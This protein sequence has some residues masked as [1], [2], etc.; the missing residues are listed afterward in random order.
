MEDPVLGGAGLHDGG[1]HKEAH[2]V[3]VLAASDDLGVGRALG[4]VN[5]PR[6][7]VKGLP[8]DDGGHEAV[9]LGDGAHLKKDS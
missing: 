9:K 8:V 7:P 3:V 4:V 5:V 1:L 2:A 6:D